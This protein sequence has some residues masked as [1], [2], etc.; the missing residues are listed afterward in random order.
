MLNRVILI[1]R[2]TKNPEL[3]YTPDGTPVARFT[4][5]VNRPYRDKQGNSLADFINIVAW[6]KLGE[7]CAQYLGK[8]QLAAVEGRLEIRTYDDKQ[9]IRH[10]ITEVIADNVRFL[11]TARKNDTSED[12]SDE[13]D[14]EEPLPF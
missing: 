14:D 11:E 4:L 12:A 8:G 1:G 6:R 10:W 3:R 5:A 9:G 7:L 13:K 2:P